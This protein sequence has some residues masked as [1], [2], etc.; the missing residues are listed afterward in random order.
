[1]QIHQDDAT[2]YDENLSNKL[3][4]FE[5]DYKKYEKGERIINADHRTI[6]HKFF[7]FFLSFFFS[8]FISFFYLLSNV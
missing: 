2:P 6:H 4:L 5:E 8:F 3:L 7:N 1:M